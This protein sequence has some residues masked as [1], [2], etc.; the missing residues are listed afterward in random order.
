MEN[1]KETNETSPRGYI[2]LTNRAT[3]NAYKIQ[4]YK[5]RLNK[6]NLIIGL[7]IVVYAVLP[8]FSLWALP[9]GLIVMFSSID[10]KYLIKNKGFRK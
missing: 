4:L 6:L 2:D 1:K 3:R 8:L 5:P 10:L 9:I 7:A